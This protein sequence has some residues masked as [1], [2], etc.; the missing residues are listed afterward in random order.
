MQEMERGEQSPAGGQPVDARGASS[1][2]LNSNPHIRNGVEDGAFSS[3]APTAVPARSP[4]GPA[5]PSLALGLGG[6][7]VAV[8]SEIDTDRPRVSD[9]ALLWEG[10]AAS[11]PSGDIDVGHA[12]DTGAVESEADD[13][14]LIRRLASADTWSRSPT[15]RTVSEGTARTPISQTR[16]S[17]DGLPLVQIAAAQSQDAPAGQRTVHDGALPGH[18]GEMRDN[19][20]SSVLAAK[21]GM[22]AEMSIGDSSGARRGTPET[23]KDR[24]AQRAPTFAQGAG[25]AV[26][27]SVSNH[28]AESSDRVSTLN[29]PGTESVLEHITVC[30][31]DIGIG[32]LNHITLPARA[33]S[34][35]DVGG[36]SLPIAT[37]EQHDRVGA[38]L[39]SVP[40]LSDNIRHAGAGRN[41]SVSPRLGTSSDFGLNAGGS[42]RLEAGIATAPRPGAT[43][44]RLAQ[45]NHAQGVG[46]DDGGGSHKA[47]TDRATSRDD[48]VSGLPPASN[49]P[50]RSNQAP[51]LLAGQNADVS[52][53]SGLAVE[54]GS[55]VASHQTTQ[56]GPATPRPVAALSHIG[57][58]D[59]VAGT[60]LPADDIRDHDSLESLRK[61][62]YSATENTVGG[63]GS[64]ASV[65]TTRTASLPSAIES[66]QASIRQ[67]AMRLASAEEHAISD[68]AGDTVDIALAALSYADAAASASPGADYNGATAVG[69]DNGSAGQDR[70]F[71]SS[72][73]CGEL[74][75]GDLPPGEREHVEGT[76]PTA[77]PLAAG[78]STHPEQSS[79]DALG[80]LDCA[81]MVAPLPLGATQAGSNGS[82]TPTISRREK[83][84]RARDRRDDMMHAMCMI[85]LD[86]FSDP[87]DGGGAKVLGLLD[88]CSHRYCYQVHGF[89]GNGGVLLVQSLGV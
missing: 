18:V 82:A 14:S 35:T 37:A 68:S 58:Q 81:P 80:S 21:M 62:R 66:G 45:G 84:A 56:S 72:S 28:C 52:A 16:I 1:G 8:K 85:C 57:P 2:N 12:C 17:C 3:S 24:D 34:R 5:I 87:A 43:G 78:A 20:A 46:Q 44:L 39:G 19:R 38:R 51:A 83:G 75:R 4:S 23:A 64:A 61:T 63:S 7:L 29:Y 76:A 50:R 27:H 59:F 67:D 11:A 47:S 33:H 40:G 9:E 55:G 88:S 13:K 54:S 48:S 41:N 42:D 31:N 49:F 89:G 86:K 26:D 70:Q 74:A 30:S 77:A 6:R 25:R 69:F 53:A 36:L 65:E 73:A 22:V 79:P 10:A 60:S 15:N 32:S 71:C